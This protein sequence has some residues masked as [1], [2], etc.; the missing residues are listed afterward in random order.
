MS[1]S[2]IRPA[3]PKLEQGFAYRNGPG[4]VRRILEIRGDRLRYVVDQPGP[5]VPR[6]SALHPIGHI[7]WCSV[8]SFRQWAV[9][10][11]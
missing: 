9:S 2:R 5:Y 11:A 8:T 10:A 6:A 7:G 3:R 4:Q 1:Y